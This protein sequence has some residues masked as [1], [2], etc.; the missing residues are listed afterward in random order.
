MS[1]FRSNKRYMQVAWYASFIIPAAYGISPDRISMISRVV[2]NS[3]AVLS[4]FVI[5]V[6]MFPV[7]PFRVLWN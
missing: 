7:N 2:D 4:Y 3:F 5:C 1:C 6:M